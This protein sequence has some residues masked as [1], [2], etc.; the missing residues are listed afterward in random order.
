YLF[1]CL[2]L[3]MACIDWE[4]RECLKYWDISDYNHEDEMDFKTMD[5]SSET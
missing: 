4:K 5:M 2:W 1:V 3:D